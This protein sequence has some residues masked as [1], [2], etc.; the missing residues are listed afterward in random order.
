MLLHFG[1]TPYLVFDGD[2]LPSKRGTEVDR[3]KRREESKA[4]GLEL[5]RKGRIAE[6][7]QE[8]QKAVDVTPYMARQV[9]EEL[10]LLKVPYVVAPYEADAQMAFLERQQIVNGIISEDS[11]LLVFGAR[12]L[13][14]KLDQHGECIEINR[15]DFS[16]CR[17]V[18]LI[19][20]TDAD[21]RRMCI[22]SGCDYLPN[23]SKLGLKTAYR[24][25]RRFKTVEKSVRMLQ[26]EGQ[27]RVP[28]DYL[29]EFKRAELTFLY[30]RVYCPASRKLVTLNPI[31]ADVK[32]EE[33]SFIGDD[34]DPEIAV[35]V[36]H[37]DL[38]PTTKQPIT[39][40]PS[41][42]T[43]KR[44]PL[45]N[46]NRR[47]TISSDMKPSRP[48]SSFFTP[49]RV[50]LAELDPNSLTPSPSQ[51]RLL[52]RHANTSWTS[53][54]VSGQ[55]SVV[56]SAPPGRVAS[57]PM[58]QQENSPAASCRN[59]SG[60]LSVKRPR[61][62]SET[63][64]P[65][66]PAHPCQS[67]FFS[68]RSSGE[69][70]EKKKPRKLEI[71]SDEDAENDA[72]GEQSVPIPLIEMPA[73]KG[74]QEST[75][76]T[77]PETN[78]CNTRVERSVNADS[79]P[80]EF[81]PVLNYH[82]QRQN[83]TLS[84]FA[85]QPTEDRDQKQRASDSNRARQSPGILMHFPKQQQRPTPLQRLGQSVLSRSRSM[86][87]PTAGSLGSSAAVETG[88]VALAQ[89]TIPH[90]GSEDMIIP[91]SDEDDPDVSDSEPPRAPARLDLQKFSFGGSQGLFFK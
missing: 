17:E 84:R 34:M 62:C 70:I 56:R 77:P 86:N 35:F 59:D 48:I 68:G 74:A 43:E 41:L 14:S 18:S 49:K 57:G 24:S 63:E 22:L 30:Q 67:R 36:A 71:F 37:G 81:L 6:A 83:S 54:P 3:Q 11:D 12:K 65:L 38:H 66:L 25:I 9:I 87:L 23:I 69:K 20:W 32:L 7:Y 75:K 82:V 5:Y 39:L 44:P 15:E 78:N 89:N 31:G 72:N 40:T 46:V 53:N 58:N 79:D 2:D 61:L 13:V 16:A 55:S 4:V 64:K 80:K 10:R 50:P 28:M 60:T 27:Y 26:L 21:F 8:L 1:I 52:Q 85:F 91:N 19:G 42:R 73:G 29:Q 90:R 45:M 88:H 47:Q 33:L 76:D 51:Q